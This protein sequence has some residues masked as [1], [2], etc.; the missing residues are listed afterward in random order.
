MAGLSLIVLAGYAAVMLALAVRVFGARRWA[1]PRASV[2]GLQ[3]R[4]LAAAL[5]V[6]V[7]NPYV[8]QSTLGD[9]TTRI[10]V[11]LVSQPSA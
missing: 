9:P 8:I 1:G 6:L 7:E 2:G 4:K 5:R 11:S 3:G 10:L